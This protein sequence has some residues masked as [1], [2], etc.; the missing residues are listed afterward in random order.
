MAEFLETHGLATP[1]ELAAM[2]AEIEREVDAAAQQAL[3]APKPAKHTA[4]QFVYSPTVDPASRDFERRTLQERP[5]EE[6]W[7][8]RWEPPE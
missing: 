3:T 4:S 2:D 6:E 5:I 1:A 8:I 7:Q